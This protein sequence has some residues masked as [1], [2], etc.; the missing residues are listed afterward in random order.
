MHVSHPTTSTSPHYDSFW[1]FVNNIQIPLTDPSPRNRPGNGAGPSIWS[2]VNAP[3]IDMVRAAGGGA[4]F[5]T[6][7]AL[8]CLKFIGFSFVDDADIIQTDEDVETPGE[9]LIPE[10]QKAVDL[11]NGGLHSSGG[12][13]KM[14]K[15]EWR[16]VDWEETPLGW[17]L[18]AIEDMPGE[19]LVW[20]FDTKARVPITRIEAWESRETLGSSSLQTDHGRIN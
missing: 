2:A 8:S 11:Y 15:C 5:R 19:L 1:S 3:I 13:L 7:I 4:V 14:D 6:A 17:K 12:A 16:L 10:I 20:N 9:L 18:R